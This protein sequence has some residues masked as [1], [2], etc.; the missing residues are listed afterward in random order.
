MK[1]DKDDVIKEL[2][3]ALAIYAD[4]RNWEMPANVFSGAKMHSRAMLDGGH[5]AKE[6]IRLIEKSRK[7]DG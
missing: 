3:L 6:A 7:K 1:L 4:D 5:I 2:T